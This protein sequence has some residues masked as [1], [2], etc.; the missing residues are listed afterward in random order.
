[1]NL[2]ALILAPIIVNTQN[3]ESTIP[4][5]VTVVIAVV[6]IIWAVRRSDRQE[7]ITEPVQQQPRPI[8]QPAAP[9]GQDPKGF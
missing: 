2:V 9:V 3:A 5:L 7:A 8:A 4:V 1:M 6:L